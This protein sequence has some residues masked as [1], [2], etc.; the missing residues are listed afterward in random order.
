MRELERI[1]AR[2]KELMRLIERRRIQSFRERQRKEL[3]VTA[4]FPE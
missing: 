3:T 1:K 4:E 2:N